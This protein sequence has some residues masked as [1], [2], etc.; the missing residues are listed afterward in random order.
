VETMTLLIVIGVSYCWTVAAVARERCGEQMPSLKLWKWLTQTW[1][2]IHNRNSVNLQPFSS[3]MEAQLWYEW[4]C[5]GV[6]LPIIVSVLLVFSGTIV[7]ARFVVLGGLQTHLQDL[8]EGLLAGGSL[9]PLAAALAGILLG[10]TSSGNRTRHHNSTIRDLDLQ[11]G[12]DQM[13]HFLATRPV[14]NSAY[15]GA[16][17]RTAVKSV[18]ISWALWVAAVGGAILLAGITGAMPQHILPPPME[19][20]FLPFTLLGAWIGITSVATAVLS[21]RAAVFAAILVLVLPG[22]ILA[23]NLAQQ[24]ASPELRIQLV[25]ILSFV[26]ALGIIGGTVSAFVQAGIRCLVR[27]SL[28]FGLCVTWLTIAVLA[29]VLGPSDLRVTAVPSIVAFAALVVL[30]FATTPL[31]IAWNRHR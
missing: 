31:A 16:I 27:T 19:T 11:N 14:S 30:P 12:F 17:L 25:N 2:K 22:G 1:E 21:G 24:F 18:G 10:S 23:T 8:H 29:W 3:L 28:V 15:A 13:G 26:V 9:L 20:W 7:L 6:A 4:R 5:K